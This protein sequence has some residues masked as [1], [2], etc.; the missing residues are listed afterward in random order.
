MYI[1]VYTYIHMY[2]HIDTH[3]YIYVYSNV[4]MYMFIH[5]C[6]YIHTYIYIFIYRCMY[7]CTYVYI[8][9]CKYVCVR[10]CVCVC[11]R[12]L[13]EGEVRVFM[14]M[15][16]Y[17]TTHTFISYGGTRTSS[18]EDM[19]GLLCE[20]TLFVHGSFAKQ[21]LCLGLFCKADLIFRRIFSYS[22]LTPDL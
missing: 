8:R 1:C 14:G 20:N 11:V 19:C 5:I 2:V 18:L 17:A 6:M 21:I 10:V 12:I 3:I 4:Y 13:G 9:A 16:L 15:P 22:S 7:L